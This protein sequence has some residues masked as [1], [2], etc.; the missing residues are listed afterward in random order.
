MIVG[1]LTILET[2]F[3][4]IL[5]EIKCGSISGEIL[6]DDGFFNVKPFFILK[7]NEKLIKS[8]DVRIWSAGTY[9]FG[10]G[11]FSSF[12]GLF[13]AKNDFNELCDD[14]FLDIL[15]LIYIFLIN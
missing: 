2:F 8:L 3:A 4:K 6:L 13:L 5:G 1:C 7:I 14:I 15:I 10:F 9:P 11:E 12:V